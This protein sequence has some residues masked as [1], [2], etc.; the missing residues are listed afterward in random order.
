MTCKQTREYS[1][2]LSVQRKCI[3]TPHHEIYTVYR[4]YVYLTILYILSVVYSLSKACVCNCTSFTT[5]DRENTENCPDQ[6]RCRG[7]RKKKSFIFERKNEKGSLRTIQRVDIH[8]QLTIIILPCPLAVRGYHRRVSGSCNYYTS[9]FCSRH[10]FRSLLLLSVE[11]LLTSPWLS[12]PQGDI[13]LYVMLHV[14]S[15]T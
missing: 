11:E 4:I 6:R 1:N 8:I 9:A 5:S 7:H 13:T 15:D 2:T 10:P 12:A 14:S 3:W